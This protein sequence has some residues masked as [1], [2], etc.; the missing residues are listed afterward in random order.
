MKAE[1]SVTGSQLEDWV[2]DVKEWAEGETKYALLHLL[3]V[4]HNL[5]RQI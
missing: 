2:C 4:A 1:L 5:C 3:M